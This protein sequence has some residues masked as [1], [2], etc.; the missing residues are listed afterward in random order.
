MSAGLCLGTAIQTGKLQRDLRVAYENRRVCLGFTESTNIPI[1]WIT[2][3]KHTRTIGYFFHK[4]IRLNV[5]HKLQNTFGG[6]FSAVRYSH[7][8]SARVQ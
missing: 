7:P 6:K 4:I 1:V 3:S 2:V 5:Q 8:D